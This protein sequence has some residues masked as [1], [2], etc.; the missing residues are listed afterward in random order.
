MIQIEGC[1]L[2]YSSVFARLRIGWEE[3]LVPI[4]TSLVVSI[5]KVDFF[6]VLG[7]VYFWVRLEQFVEPRRS[8]SRGTY[9]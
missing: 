7:H 1:N 5:E 9:T 6:T 2:P 3:P 8:R 4:N